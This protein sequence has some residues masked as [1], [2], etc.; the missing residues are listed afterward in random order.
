MMCPDMG[1]IGMMSP[2]MRDPGLPKPIADLFPARF[3]DS[4]M[5]RIPKGWAV[6][7]LPAAFEIN[8]SR[9]LSKCAVAPYL[10]MANMPT[11]FAR[12]LAWVEREFTSGMKF[13]NGDVLVARITPCLENGKT[14]Y[15]D[16]LG[17]G[18]VGW[19]STEFIVLRSRL[20]LPVEYAYFLAR[21]EDFR[22]YAIANMTGTS[23][24]Q[25]VPTTCFDAFIIPVP[26]PE[27]AERFGKV[28]SAAM[29]TI[30]QNDE[31]TQIL[32]ALRDALLPKLLSGEI[33]IKDAEK[34]IGGLA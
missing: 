22:T 20:P 21:S 2:D 8:P 17:D 10:D 9:E 29:S 6:K 5:G 30:R 16:F 33:R 12:P 31:Q 14:A 32:A 25:R 4:E 26:S 13:V 23:G 27:V 3:Q 19:G 24:R 11:D 7:P 1:E 34:F 18:Q 28:A 15:V